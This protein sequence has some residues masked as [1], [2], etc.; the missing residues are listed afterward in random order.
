MLTLQINEITWDDRGVI[1]LQQKNKQR[2]DF[3]GNC[4]ILQNLNTK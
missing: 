4:I 1:C 2:F 3:N